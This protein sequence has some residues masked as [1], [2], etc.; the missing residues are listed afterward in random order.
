MKEEFAREFDF[1]FEE[2]AK[3][4]NGDS[5]LDRAIGDAEAELATAIDRPTVKTDTTSGIE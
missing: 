2:C 4:W 3:L 5:L 1:V